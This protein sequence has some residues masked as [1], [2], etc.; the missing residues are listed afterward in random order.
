METSKAY[1][2]VLFV[3]MGCVVRIGLTAKD[4]DNYSTGNQETV[5]MV[6]AGAPDQQ[7]KLMLSLAEFTA[8]HKA[9]MGN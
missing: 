6:P 5:I 7:E 1:P 2:F 4:M 3:K 9:L 8:G